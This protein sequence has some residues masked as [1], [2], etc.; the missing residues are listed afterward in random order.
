MS[1]ASARFIPAP[2]AGPFTAAMMGLGQS[3]MARMVASR[4]GAIF[5]LSE[6][7]PPARSRSLI[8]FTSPPEQK[9]RPAPVMT[10]TRTSSSAP[11]RR[12]ASCRSSR[13]VSPSAFSRSGRFSVRVAI[14]SCTS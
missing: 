8:D 3:R 4:C 2:A 9:P 6:D 1:H 5:S 13:S 7:V 11:E 12:I 10:S 14:R